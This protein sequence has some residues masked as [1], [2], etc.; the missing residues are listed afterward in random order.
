MIQGMND[1]PHI[2]IIKKGFAVLKYEDRFNMR[3]VCIFDC[4]IDA[5]NYLVKMIGE[6]CGEVY[7]IKEIQGKVEVGNNEKG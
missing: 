6:K 7:P 3:V 5:H 4:W 1:K 2:S